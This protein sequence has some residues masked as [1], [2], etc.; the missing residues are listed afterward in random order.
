LRLFYSEFLYLRLKG[1][2]YFRNRQ[3]L[4]FRQRKLLMSTIYRII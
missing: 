2:L 4:T 3:S 1:I